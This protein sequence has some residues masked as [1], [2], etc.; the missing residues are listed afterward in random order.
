MTLDSGFLIAFLSAFVRC[1]AMLLSSPMFGKTVPVK[2]RIL[3]SLMVSMALAPVIRPY[4]G[5]VP[6]DM[7]SL[8][9]LVGRDVFVGVLIGGMMQILLAAFQIAGGFLDIQIGIGSAQIF[10]PQMGAMS[11]PIGQFK[12]MLG[13][14]LLL[15]LDAH[16]MMFQAFVASY[17]LVGPTVSRVGEMQTAIMGFMGQIS[18]MAMQIAAPVAAVAVLIDVVAGLI[19]KA[20]PQTMPFLLAMPAKMIAGMFALA[21]GLPA[22]VVAARS[23]IDFTF[24]YMSQMLGG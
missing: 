18:L 3:F 20:V 6:Q 10:N 4:V 7:V 23:G 1:S 24:D 2:V 15:L 16:H 13:L 12:Y 5:E 22:L 19:N 17:D 9:L 8:A 11:S 21:L 14:V